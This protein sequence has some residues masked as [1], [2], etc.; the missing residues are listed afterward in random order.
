M[1]CMLCVVKNYF[2]RLSPW[3]TGLESP[4]YFLSTPVWIELCIISIH[5]SIRCYSLNTHSYWHR[6]VSFPSSKHQIARLFRKGRMEFETSRVP[7][8]VWTEIFSYF[9][10]SLRTPKWQLF[11]SALEPHL[12]CTTLPALASLLYANTSI[13]WRSQFSIVP[14]FHLRKNIMIQE[15]MQPLFTP[16]FKNPGLGHKNYCLSLNEQVNK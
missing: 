2:V 16:L 14:L 12:R 10:G 8:E 13:E 1:F 4:T 7:D 5:V 11:G 6:M 9:K 15:T 3:L